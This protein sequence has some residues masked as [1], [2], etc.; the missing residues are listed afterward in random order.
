MSCR[1]RHACIYLS[2]LYLQIVALLVRLATAHLATARSRGSDEILVQRLI[3]IAALAT[4]L[5]HDQHKESNAEDR[6]THGGGH[7]DAH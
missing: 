1:V 7:V 5:L 6:N 2:C 3:L 4:Q